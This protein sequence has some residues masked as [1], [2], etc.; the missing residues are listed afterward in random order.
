[1]RPPVASSRPSQLRCQC[2]RAL[3]VNERAAI[4]NPPA[5]SLYRHPRSNGDACSSPSNFG[6]RDPTTDLPRLLR[7]CTPDMRPNNACASPRSP[8]LPPSALGSRASSGM[9]CFPTAQRRFKRGSNERTVHRAW[10]VPLSRSHPPRPMTC[11]PV[12][13][14]SRLRGSYREPASGQKRN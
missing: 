6:T 9:L 5:T 14:S 3:G 8:L 7:I 12:G 11:R 2:G 13:S 1:M 10:S 4:C